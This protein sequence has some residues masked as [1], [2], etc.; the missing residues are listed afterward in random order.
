MRNSS[1]PTVKRILAADEGE[2]D[3]QLEQEL[4]QMLQQAALQVALVRF[5]AEHQKIEVV[6]IFG[7]FLREIGLRRRE[8]A[9]EV[10]DG[11]SLAPVEIAL[12]LVNQNRP[13]PAVMDGGPS[14]PDTL[15]TVGNLVEQDAVVE[16]RQLC[17]NLLHKFLLGPDLGEA[18]HILEVAG[19]EAF[20]VGKRALQVR[21]QAIDDLGA[22]AFPLLPIEDVAADLPIKQDQFAVDRNRGA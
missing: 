16:P 15:V 2:P 13:A 19:R 14:V 8:G 9:I 6:G 18:P 11:F 12:D 7:D 10:G 17:S 3:S 20:H 21:R 4:S 1:P 22:P 5:F